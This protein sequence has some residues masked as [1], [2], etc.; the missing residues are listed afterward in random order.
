MAVEAEQRAGYETMMRTQMIDRII[1]YLRTA[2]H[3]HTDA[4][5]RNGTFYDRP[6]YHWSAAQEDRDLI[7][8]LE[9]IKT[10]PEAFFAS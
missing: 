3:Q 1:S 6:D 2:E 4:A 5:K 9:E 7:K 8:W 10:N